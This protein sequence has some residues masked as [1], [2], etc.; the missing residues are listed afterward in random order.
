L[1]VNMCQPEV[2]W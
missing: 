2:G 1:G